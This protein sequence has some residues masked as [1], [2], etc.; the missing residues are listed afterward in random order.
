MSSQVG[1]TGLE[2]DRR[3]GIADLE[4]GHI[5]TARREPRLFFASARLLSS[6][7]VRITL[8]SGEVLSSNHDLSDWLGR[9]VELRRAGAAG[10]VYENPLDFENESDWVSW[11]GPAEAWHDSTRARVSFVSTGTIGSWD[12]RRFRP[13]VLLDGDGEDDLV[14]S[15]LR[16]GSAEFE[17]TK[18]IDRCIMVTRAQP[19]IEADLDVL[20]RINRDR[21]TR[22]A[23]G[24]LVRR[25]GVIRVGDAIE[26]VS[27]AD[28][29]GRSIR[30]PGNH[31]HLRRS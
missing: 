10:G 20:R 22:L 29:P 12:V 19:G 13:N 9:S 18:Q 23:V 24:A 16:V 30:D 3:W 4:T 14:G 8:S 28:R 7:A 6:E 26:M 2:G 21:R 15:G 17:I 27:T 25:P 5:L 31:S 1:H 11:Q